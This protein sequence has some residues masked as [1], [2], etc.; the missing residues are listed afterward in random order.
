MI[1]R[2]FSLIELLMA[3]FILGI[4]LISI[5][6]LFP[7]GIALQQRAEDELNGPIV[8][9][10]ALEVI[11]GR[12]SGD[13]FGS[14][15]DF[16]D[17]QVDYVAWR[18]GA[19]AAETQQNNTNTKLYN[20]RLEQPAA[21]LNHE[22]WPWLRPAMVVEVTDPG[23]AATGAIKP[24]TLDIFNA[25]GFENKAETVGEH[26]LVAAHPWQQML[27]FPVHDTSTQFPKIGI[28][29]NARNIVTE[30]PDTGLRMDP[31]LISVPRVLITPEERTWPQADAMGRV[32]KYFW[33]CAFRRVGSDVQVAIF[34]YRAQRESMTQPQWM[35]GPV[36]RTDAPGEHFIPVPWVFDL[37]AGA[38]GS[39]GPWMVGG[40]S[41]AD[42][43]PGTDVLNFTQ[44]GNSNAEFG[45]DHPDFGWMWPGQWLVDQGGNVHRVASG[46]TVSD[47][48]DANAKPFSLTAP[49]PS[50]VAAFQLDRAMLDDDQYS[51]DPQLFTASVI[52]P[53]QSMSEM[54]RSDHFPSGLIRDHRDLP[55]TQWQP[56]VDRIW[57]VPPVVDT[58]TGTYR[59]IPIY[60]T[61]GSL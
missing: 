41:G 33:D 28:P 61:V 6:A 54:N 34:V 5:A 51:D 30:D 46:L 47:D 18:D 58:G 38:N 32:P 35:S 52:L 31:P 20:A 22:T 11:R 17:A 16:R 37:T 55:S 53:T 59:L 60:V 25:L 56:V 9:S 45:P 15:W 7:A 48:P 8:A 40:E 19:D 50:P 39:F 29:F 42:D 1:R 4:G 21:W 36:T 3:I 14:W 44:S 49:I 27:S 12:L 43:F 23:I 24:G 10:H 2:A 26:T 13:D 57:Y